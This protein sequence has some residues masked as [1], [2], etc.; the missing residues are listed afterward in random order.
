MKS[1]QEGYSCIRIG[2]AEQKTCPCT[3]CL[4]M[5]GNAP[6]DGGNCHG[7]EYHDFLFSN[8][9]NLPEFH[10]KAILSWSCRCKSI[11]HMGC[12]KI[13][14]RIKLLWIANLGICDSDIEMDKLDL[15][16]FIKKESE[17]RRR[18]MIF[19][20]A[21][22]SGVA[23]GVM[24]MNINA[25][26]IYEASRLLAGSAS[27]AVMVVFSFLYTAYLSTPAFRISLLL[28]TLAIVNYLIKYNSIGEDLDICSRMESELFGSLNH[29]L[30]GFKEIEVNRVKSD[31]IFDNY[32]RKHLE[33][34]KVQELKTE[35]RLIAN[36]MSAQTCIYLLNASIV[37][38]LLRLS[39]STPD[40]VMPGRLKAEGK[41]IIAIT[42]DDRYFHVSDRVIRMEYG[43]VVSEKKGADYLDA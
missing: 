17:K 1:E 43:K 42:H 32:F 22:I 41:T 7:I 34:A 12:V 6:I 38:L 23:N 37:F 35:S 36:R 4:L 20:G 24:V 40:I 25:V 29:L 11:L 15:V 30:S 39:G 26:I 13:S 27:S 2:E 31:D 9:L 33:T 19:V 14:L 21:S 5:N 16:S 10:E 8:N 18:G 28:L 3:N